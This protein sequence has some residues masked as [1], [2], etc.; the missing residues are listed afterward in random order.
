MRTVAVHAVRVAVLVV[1]GVLQEALGRLALVLGA[2]PRHDPVLDGHV[3]ERLGGHQLEQPAQLGAEGLPEAVVAGDRGP[4]QVGHRGVQDLAVE[5]LLHG[6]A[7]RGG[8]ELAGDADLGDP[9]GG[10]AA[11]EQALLPQ[12]AAV[13]APAPAVDHRGDDVD[14]LGPQ[15]R[16]DD[17]HDVGVVAL[18][19]EGEVVLVPEGATEHPGARHQVRHDLG[20][21]V[22]GD[23]DPAVPVGAL[24]PERLLVLALLLE[25]H[26]PD[27]DVR[28]ARV[29]RAGE[30]FVALREHGVV[31]VA[32]REVAALGVRHA[33]VAGRAD[34]A[35]RLA[36]QPDVAVLTGQPPGHLGR[37]VHGAVVDQD[38]LEVGVG[39]RQQ[40]VD[41]RLELADGGVERHHD[42][43]PG[44]HRAATAQHRPLDELGAAG[45]LRTGDH[46]LGHRQSSSGRDRTGTG[47]GGT[48][49]GDAARPTG[50]RG[51]I[52]PA[53]PC[54]TTG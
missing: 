2:Q 18:G 20:V 3:R 11:V 22:E 35:V 26:G 54:A 29:Q 50:G 4:H 39:L 6:L 19:G 46:R 1:E 10:P 14:E 51:V 44:Q 42:A 32:E 16:L 25:G 36:D 52:E 27:R 49:I 34:A 43:E 28:A 8:D 21:L 40:A 13:L 47:P 30:P 17:R 9:V 23:A 5:R 48:M 7:G 12:R 53:R 15:H 41:T 33:G 31:G 38:D 37:A 45:A 24:G